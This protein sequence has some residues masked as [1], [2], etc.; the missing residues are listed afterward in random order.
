MISILD[1]IVIPCLNPCQVVKALPSL[2]KKF[3]DVAE[4]MFDPKPKPGSPINPNIGFALLRPNQQGRAPSRVQV[5]RRYEQLI[6][7]ARFMHDSDYTPQV[8]LL[9]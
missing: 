8:I 7:Q 6:R 3:K 5:K 4:T 2:R 1:L 9:A